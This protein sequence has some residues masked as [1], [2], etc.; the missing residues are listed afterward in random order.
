MENS[1]SIGYTGYK[2]WLTSEK[3]MTPFSSLPNEIN[4]LIFEYLTKSEQLELRLVSKDLA[5]ISATHLTQYLSDEPDNIPVVF[6][7]NFLKNITNQFFLVHPKKG[8]A[9]IDLT[10]NCPASTPSDLLITVGSSIRNIRDSIT[11]GH[12]GVFNVRQIE[13]SFPREW[14]ASLHELAA[15]ER[16]LSDLIEKSFEFSFISLGFYD[17]YQGFRI[18]NAKKRG[19]SIFSNEDFSCPILCF[20]IERHKDSLMRIELTNY[21][22]SKSLSGKTLKTIFLTLKEFQKLK[23]L[24]LQGLRIEDSV[25]F[26]IELLNENKNINSV[27]LTKGYFYSLTDNKPKRNNLKFVIHRNFPQVIRT[28]NEIIGETVHFFV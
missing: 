22:S 11:Y 23:V 15:G 18:N 5:V 9:T 16:I 21:D 19:S 27:H 13:E 26:L 8:V 25:E 3:E 4:F 7:K 1:I 10:R 12:A 28:Q 17:N 6:V 24:D 20:Q 14:K 2:R